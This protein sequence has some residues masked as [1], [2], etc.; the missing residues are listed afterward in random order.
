[1]AVVT[2]V[3]FPV[4]AIGC[5]HRIAAVPL[6]TFA[7]LPERDQVSHPALNIPQSNWHGFWPV[8]T[9]PARRKG[10]DGVGV[11]ASGVEASP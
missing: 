7:S 4:M 3:D 2:A 11:E 8:E 6:L 10:F 1:M 9:A 5:L